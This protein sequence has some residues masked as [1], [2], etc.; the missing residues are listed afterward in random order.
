M[1]KNKGQAI[2]RNMVFKSGRGG[3]QIC[4]TTFLLALGFV[5]AVIV[6]MYAFVLY[7]AGF[8]EYTSSSNYI[9]VVNPPDSFITYREENPYEDSLIFYE[10]WD[11]PYDFMKMSDLLHEHAAGIAVVFPDDFDDTVKSGQNA[12]V[13]TYYRTDT[14]D[15]KTIRDNFTDGYLTDYKTYLTKIYNLPA[16]GDAWNVIRGDTLTNGDMSGFMLFARA[17]GRNFLPILLFITLLYTAMSNGT[18]AISGQKERGTFSRILLTPVPRRNIIS[19]FT[20]GVFISA[21][22][23]AAI[24]IILAVLIPFYRFPLSL[25]PLFILTLSLSLFISALTVM[26]SVMNDTVSSAQT[27]FLPV[28]FI[29]VSV[30]VT[31]INGGS[32]PEKFYYFIPIYGQFY[33]LG[34]AFNGEPEYLSAIVCSALTTLLGVLVMMISTKIL[35]NERFTSTASSEDTDETEAPSLISSVFGKVSGIIDVV[36]FPLFILSVFQILAM[37]PVAVVYMRKPEYSD[38]IASLV[39]VETVSDIMNRTMDIL[40][41]FMNDGR[42]LALMSLSY[43]LII[44]SCMRRARGASRVGLIKKDFGRLY[45]KGLI[46][47]SALM[48]LTFIALLITRKV[49]VE[50]VGFPAS[51]ALVFV[52]SF[53]MWIPQGAAEEVMFRGYMMPKIKSLF[54]E[55]S[56]AG[57]VTAIVVSSILF[58]V[59]HC[60]NGGFNFVALLNIFL[61]AVLF[62]LIFEKTGSIALTCAAH[63][64]WN[65]FQGNI[66]G[67]SVSGNESVPSLLVTNYTGSDFGPEGTVEA[68]VIIVI[69]LAAFAVLNRRKKQS[70]PKAS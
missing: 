46:V 63:T 66:Y 64:M 57:T 31:C 38:F 35:S 55:K 41:I 28:F 56:K 10:E 61:L 40:G 16:T 32:D 25:I 52:F 26:I 24:I 27:A 48:T 70:S 33:G 49:S 59:F 18:E 60:F 42:F 67:L 58:S 47:G 19:S 20:E 2:T 37:I 4:G 65:L 9:V 12:E 51:K 14:L 8:N 36:F 30:A 11:A 69:A 23:P 5:W 53:L 34:N 7:F 13:L 15:Y 54:R 6:C 43:I 39:N 17:M 1:S 22:I 62:A 21:S 68:T 3:T 29:L 50:G 45:G 44:L